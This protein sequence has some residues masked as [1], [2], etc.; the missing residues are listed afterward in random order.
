MGILLYAQKILFQDYSETENLLF[1]S[2]NAKINM[3]HDIY[4]KM[5]ELEEITLIEI[6]KNK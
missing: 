2:M 1:E 5:I 3:T 4:N 6:I